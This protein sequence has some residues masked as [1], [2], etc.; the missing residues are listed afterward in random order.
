MS[1]P[2]P[3]LP[4]VVFGSTCPRA[5]EPCRNFHGRYQYPRQ[6]GDDGPRSDD[7]SFIELGPRKI[8]GCCFGFK[9]LRQARM[10]PS[11]Q[12]TVGWHFKGDIPNVLHP[13]DTAALGLPLFHLRLETA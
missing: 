2:S 1:R 13:A 8:L 9:R 6:V 4:F 11:W 12:R 7:Q 3:E 5:S 10:A